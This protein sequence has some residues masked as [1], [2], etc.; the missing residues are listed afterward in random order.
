VLQIYPHT[1]YKWVAILVCS[2]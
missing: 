1:I 2:R